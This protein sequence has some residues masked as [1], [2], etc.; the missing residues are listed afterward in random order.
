MGEEY[1]AVLM[2]YFAVG[3]THVMVLTPNMWDKVQSQVY[4]P[5]P[6][7]KYKGVKLT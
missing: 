6:A 5:I 1:R 7:L 4:G 3:R 2:Y